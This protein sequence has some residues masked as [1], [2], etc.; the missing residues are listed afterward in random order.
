MLT[1]ERLR[2]P[3]VHVD[4]MGGVGRGLKSVMY[5]SMLLSLPCN[6]TIRKTLEYMQSFWFVTK[7]MESDGPFTPDFFRDVCPSQKWRKVKL[8][9]NKIVESL[10]F[11]AASTVH[12]HSSTASQS[13]TAYFPYSLTCV[14]V[15][16]ASDANTVCYDFCL[17]NI[18]S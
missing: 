10:C 11:H 15:S 18:S 2:T 6:Q 8:R 12:L 5:L 1:I 9:N 3:T 17:P 14:L 13:T 4:S 16:G 7:R